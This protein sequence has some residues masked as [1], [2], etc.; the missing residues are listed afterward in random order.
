MI[1]R[2]FSLLFLLISVLFWPFWVSIIL[3]LIGIIYFSKYWE[4]IILFLLSDL[5]Y[6]IREERFFNIYFISF[7]VSLLT[8]IIIEFLKKKLRI[9]N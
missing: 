1:L 3:G 5:L 4:S 7:I 6:G 2:I 8:L 9:Q